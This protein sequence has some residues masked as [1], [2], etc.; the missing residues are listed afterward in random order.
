MVIH[1]GGGLDDFNAVTLNTP[2]YAYAYK[3]A[4]FDGFSRLKAAAGGMP[5]NL[6]AAYSRNA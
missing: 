5:P 2:T 3:Y 4:A 6:Q 1:L